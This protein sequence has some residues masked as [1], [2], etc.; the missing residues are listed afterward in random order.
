MQWLICLLF[1]FF[2]KLGC[3]TVLSEYSDLFLICIV[4]YRKNC[5]MRITTQIPTSRALLVLVVIC[6]SEIP[7]N[8]KEV[9]EDE[10]IWTFDLCCDFSPCLE[11]FQNLTRRA[12]GECSSQV[13]IK[14]LVQFRPYGMYQIIVLLPVSTKS[15]LSGGNV[16]SVHPLHSVTTELCFHLQDIK[17]YCIALLSAALEK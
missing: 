9:A 14:C 3:F 13:K 10:L 7:S 17:T 1:F 12:H 4:Q 6:M 5:C 15:S 8:M 2:L 16:A 11:Q